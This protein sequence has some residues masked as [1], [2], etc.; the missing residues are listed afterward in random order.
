MYNSGIYSTLDELLSFRFHVKRAK[1]NHQQK[2]IA[3]KAG[4]HQAIR[5]GRGMTFTEVREYQAGDEIRHIDWKVT[6]RTQKTHTKV[7]TEE[8]EKPVVCITEQTSKLFF[9]SQTRF[10]SV[11]ALNVSVI[12]GWLSIQAGDKFG[13]QIFNG[14]S[15]VWSPIKANHKALMSYCHVGLECQK[16]IKSPLEELSDT[17][18][19]QE[20]SKLQ[21]QTQSGNRIFLIGDFLDMDEN[22]FQ[23]LSQLKKRNQCT[24]IHIYDPLEKQL[25]DSKKGL[26]N[27]SVSD[28]NNTFLLSRNLLKNDHYQQA[29]Q[30]AWLLLK[31][32]CGQQ[33]IPL[34]EIDASQNPVS[35]LMQQQVIV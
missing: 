35:Q 5:K 13:G 14:K 21:K 22:F 9:G 24:L 29:Y 26:N 12:L 2:L 20:L 19:L 23:Q 28:G 4:Y 11:Q 10:K 1:I 31:E 6:A 16:A 8:L 15:S 34:I 33:H 30:Q 32:H 25:P 27:L 7:F 18:W 17:L 3:A